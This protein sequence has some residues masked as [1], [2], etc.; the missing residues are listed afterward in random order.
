[1]ALDLY[2]SESADYKRRAKSGEEPETQKPDTDAARKRRIH[3]EAM[4]RFRIVAEAESKQ[5][6][7]ELEDLKFDRALPEDQWPADVLN[8]RQGGIG[9][10]GRM[11]PPRPCLTI[12]RLD[13]PV[14]TVINEARQ[15]RL[16]IQV[17]P[18]GKGATSKTADVIQ[19]IIRAIEVDSRAQ[20]ARIW[21]LERAAKCGRGAYRILIER[22]NDGD[23]Q[24]DI[25]IKR[26]PNQGCVYFDPHA[27]EPDHSDGEWCLITEDLPKA[28]FKRRYKSS[29]L[30]R[31]M[32]T[33]ELQSL[34]DTAP[35]W[36][37]D[38][39]IRVA[40]YFYLR[41][42]EK[43]PLPMDLR[44]Q[45][46]AEYLEDVT[47]EGLRARLESLAGAP[48]DTTAVWWCVIDALGVL[49]E[50]EW[51][52]RH[53]PVVPVI[54][55]EYNVNGERVY[56]G[57]VSNSKDAQR[58]Y[59]VMR[60]AQVEAVGLAPKSPF[61]AAEGQVEGYEQ[62]WA[63]A[64][65]RNYSYL[66]Y[67]P[68]ALGDHLV[69]PPA[70][71]T[72]EPAIQAISQA[73]REAENDIKATTG[74]FDPSLGNFSQE[75]SGKALEAMQQQG[76]MGTS[77]Y[78]DNLASIS[79]HYEAKCLL[80]LIPKVY[81]EPG[82]IAR[83]LGDQ[84]Q[85]EK[86]VMLNQPFV[87]QDGQPQAAPPDAPNAQMY[88]LKLGQYT[89]VVSVGRAFQTQ[90]DQ[91]LAVLQSLI[92]AVPDV[93][94]QV[95]DL[96]AEHLDG[97]MATRMAERF[98][99]L[100][101]QLAD[102]QSDLPPAA[103]AQIGQLTQQMQQMQ[104]VV[105]EAQQREAIEAKKHELQQ[106]TEQIKIQGQLQVEASKVES[107]R[108]THLMTLESNQETDNRKLALQMQIEEMKL[109]AEERRL[110]KELA[111]KEKIERMK[112]EL[113]LA[114]KQAETVI[115]LQAREEQQASEHAHAHEMAETTAAHARD[116]ATHAALVQVATEPDQPEAS[117]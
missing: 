25:V 61:I 60:S 79:M 81:Y 98:R 101:P 1:M 67:K 15:A 110:D 112:L 7:R 89:V 2:S 48:V 11:T 6:L 95:I 107:Q 117:A 49:K 115:E 76:Q 23:D 18:K 55:K 13:Q 109:A 50:Q 10:D 111:H 69:P 52:G 82:R 96:L 38:E 85:D 12:T 57:I 91:N 72:A 33:T 9:A 62:T 34:T 53:I 54:G 16:A 100:N 26:I 94:M 102:E 90:R 45:V 56:K 64:N 4:D 44:A 40:E 86:Q 28:E 104:Q 5:R 116:G 41:H 47:D 105:A 73:V 19:G 63:Q 87:M 84:P 42:T 66:P 37:T 36:L 93:T 68:V 114:A 92:E 113:T 27:Q 74:L 43:R 103:Q 83:L 71:N 65:I 78:L 17:K 31:Q 59:N 88:D 70:R 106:Q 3:E 8:A 24:L 20:I 30:N 77:N 97:P 75:R 80:D 21:A 46:G 99:K 35:G 32:D 22:Q 29:P 108:Q 39:T 51:P 14:Q 58:S